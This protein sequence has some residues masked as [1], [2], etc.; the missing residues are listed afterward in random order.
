MTDPR[1]ELQKVGCS[2]CGGCG[3]YDT[4]AESERLTKQG[5]TTYCAARQLWGDGLCECG[6]EVP[7][8]TE[9]NG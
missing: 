1:Q 7:K 3:K 9:I 5:H 2:N 6:K 4:E 8:W